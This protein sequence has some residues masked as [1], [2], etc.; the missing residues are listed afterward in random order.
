MN[1][2]TLD[3]GRAKAG[4]ILEQ[5]KAARARRAAAL[6]QHPAPLELHARVEGAAVPMA[7]VTRQTAGFL[8]AVGD[9]WFDYPFG[10]ILSELDEGFGFSVESSAHHGDTLE[11]MAYQ[12]GGQLAKFAKNLEK[13]TAQAAVPKAVLISGGGDDIAGN[14]FGMLLNDANSA[15]EGWNSEILQ[16]LLEDRLLTAFRF[17]LAAI[18]QICSTTLGQ[19]IPIVIHGYDFPVPDGRGFLGGGLLLPGPWLRPGFQ[20]K[21]F[22]DLPTTVALMRQIINRF[23]DMLANLPTESDFQNVHVVDLRGTLSTDLTDDAYKSSWDNELHPTRS[24]FQAVTAK[25]VAVLNTLP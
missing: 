17:T 10:D 21:S 16:G 18:N 15:I 6:A 8:V 2:R 22:G 7:A 23:N 1:D 25:F 4:T 13:V 12:V 9:S 5:R 20:E 19:A 14:E 11:S 3:L 24:G